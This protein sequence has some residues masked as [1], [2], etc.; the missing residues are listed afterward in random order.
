MP[1]PRPRSP[2]GA[3]TINQR[4][5]KSA[6]ARYGMAVASVA[7]A[8]LLTAA[9]RLAFEQTLRLRK[10]RAILIDDAEHIAKAARGSK[11]FYIG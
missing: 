5:N 4:W 6:W 9:L 10:P 11:L 3:Q 7:S 8:A 1:D 2:H